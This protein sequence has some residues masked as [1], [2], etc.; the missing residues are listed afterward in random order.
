MAWRQRWILL[1]FFAI[2]QVEAKTTAATTTAPP[3]PKHIV[4]LV[5]DDY[6]FGDASYKQAMYSETAPPPTPNIDE[7]ALNLKLLQHFCT[8]SLVSILAT[9]HISN[10]ELCGKFAGYYKYF[11]HP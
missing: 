3:P 10:V 9:Y 2:L 4:F 6:G 5:I 11:E 1:V 7:L 8:P